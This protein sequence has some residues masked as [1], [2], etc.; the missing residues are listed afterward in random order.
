M[1]SIRETSRA[2]KSNRRGAA[3]FEFAL[4]APLLVSFIFGS[5]ELGFVMFS[6]SSMQLA[7]DI[8][9]RQ[10]SVN[11]ATVG[12][13]NDTVKAELPIWLRDY[14]TVTVTQTD[15]KDARKNLIRVT[16]AAPAV[17]A[18]PIPIVTRAL[19]WNLT[20]DVAVVQELPF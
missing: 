15:T 18:T 10:V 6:Y 16:I 9:A 11:T 19:T 3:A 4:I 17:H 14:A 7:A 20:T 1:L 13:V 8:A 12:T 5:L 2:F